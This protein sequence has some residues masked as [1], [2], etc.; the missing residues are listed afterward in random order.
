MGNSA[1][2]ERNEMNEKAYQAFVWGMLILGCALWM[3]FLT[4]CAAEP[5]APIQKY[6]QAYGF[7][8]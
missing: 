1:A 6:R 3:Y 4:G 8:P 5:E 7:S 2:R